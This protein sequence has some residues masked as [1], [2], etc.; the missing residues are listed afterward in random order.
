MQDIQT[1]AYYVL[2]RNISTEEVQAVLNALRI[3]PVICAVISNVMDAELAMVCGS[4]V[5]TAGSEIEAHRVAMQIALDS[6][7]PTLVIGEANL[8]DAVYA[9]GTKQEVASSC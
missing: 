6:N 5:I 2:N 3:T 7:W 9:D 1:P 8:L 4:K